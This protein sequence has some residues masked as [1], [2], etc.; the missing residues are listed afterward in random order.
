[1]ALEDLTGTKYINSL[2]V[3]NPDGATDPKSQGDDHIR[4][5]KNT[6]KNTFPNVT[7]AVT[8]DQ[9]ELNKLDG[10]TLSTAQLNASYFAGGTDVAVADGGTGAST[11]AGARTNL[12]L[13]S[14]ATLNSVGAAQITD[15]S[16]DTAELA[17]G[18]VTNVKLGGSAVNSAK[19][20]WSS[21]AG[22]QSIGAGAT[23]VM[24]AGL[25][26]IYKSAGVYLE[27]YTGAAWE[28]PGTVSTTAAVYSDGTNMRLYNDA[29]TSA[30]VSY[31]K[32]A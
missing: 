12:G 32:L 20:A 29:V 10:C 27:V 28:R 30:T 18:A 14:L 11:A 26:M 8:A 13:G 17:N 15:G 19:V 25:Y 6:L 31:R 16:V 3:T 1:M 7:G 5:I 9:A 24:P 23:W 21:S 22:S 4:G 2:V